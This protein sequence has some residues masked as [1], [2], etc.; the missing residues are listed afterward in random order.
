M[1]IVW[2]PQSLEDIEQNGDYIA[3]DSPRSAEKFVSEIIDLVEHLQTYP[4]SG[5]LIEENPMFRHVVHQGYRIVYYLE[6]NQIN[7]ITVL[8]PGRLLKP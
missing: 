7:I 1:E 2:S 3:K 6:N 4:E 8:S 5:A